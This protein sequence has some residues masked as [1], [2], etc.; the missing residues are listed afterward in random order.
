MGAIIGKEEMFGDAL[1]SSLAFHE[2]ANLLLSDLDEDA[3][4]SS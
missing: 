3:P 2:K 1:L 4:I